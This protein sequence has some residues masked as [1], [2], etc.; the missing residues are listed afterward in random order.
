MVEQMYWG[1][2]E[3]AG[4]EVECSLS[5]SRWRENRVWFLAAGFP[6]VMGVPSHHPLGRF[7]SHQ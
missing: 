5:S 7:G 2:G 3:E 6:K 1:L 4:S